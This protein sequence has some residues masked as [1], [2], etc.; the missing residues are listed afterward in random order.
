[1]LPASSGRFC[2][3]SLALMREFYTGLASGADAAESLRRAKL[4]M[5]QVFGTDVAPKLWSGVV[6]YGDGMTTIA[7]SPQTTQWRN[8]R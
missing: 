8:W 1:V 6:V 4:R 7:A 2:Q 3:F 5:L